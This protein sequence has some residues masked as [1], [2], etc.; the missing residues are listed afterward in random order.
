MCTFDAVRLAK[1]MQPGSFHLLETSSPLTLSI[2]RATFTVTASSGPAVVHMALSTCWFGVGENRLMI[3]PKDR[4]SAHIVEFSPA[5]VA[6][7][8]DC[9]N[10]LLE[11]GVEI[12]EVATTSNMITNEEVER[13]VNLP[14]FQKYLQEAESVLARRAAL[15]LSSL[16]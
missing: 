7:V 2:G 6:H 16:F 13:L 12:T 3:V 4:G 8:Q 10:A 15:Q 5:S 9:R 1:E 14:G 11:R